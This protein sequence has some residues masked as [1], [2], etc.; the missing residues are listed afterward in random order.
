M[1]IEEA[2]DV[3]ESAVPVDAH[4]GQVFNQAVSV[5]EDQL[6]GMSAKIA[7]LA[8]ELAALKAAHQWQP[9]ETA[10]KDGT[11]VLIFGDGETSIAFFE[12]RV[13]IGDWRCLGF[14]IMA[15][16]DD[17][18]VFSRP[19]SLFHPNPTHWAPLPESPA[20]A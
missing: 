14:G 6:H 15:C 20:G 9:I 13:G 10:P 4:A 7:C 16:E 12:V 17:G 5:I 19:P 1:D 2:L 3:I 18:C 11:T 8:D